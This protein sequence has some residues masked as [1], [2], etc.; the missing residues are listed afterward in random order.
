MAKPM[1]ITPAIRSPIIKI[2]LAQINIY[3]RAIIAQGLK[4]S[5]KKQQV[6]LFL[7]NSEEFPSL[8]LFP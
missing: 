2:S 1:K 7:I 6:M 3:Y 5:N 8:R 4:N